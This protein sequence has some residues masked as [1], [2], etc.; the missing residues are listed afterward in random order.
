MVTKEQET[1][2]M[3]ASVTLIKPD[4]WIVYLLEKTSP[5]TPDNKEANVH[6]LVAE[7]PP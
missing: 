7:Q 3:R 2:V 6:P 1:Q 4:D 5:K